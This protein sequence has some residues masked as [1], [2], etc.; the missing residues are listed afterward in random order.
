MAVAY[1]I[2]EIILVTMAAW[3]STLM[4]RKRFFVFSFILF[5]AA[6]LLCGSPVPSK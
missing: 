1:S 4:G 6:S 5:T 3:F 2:S